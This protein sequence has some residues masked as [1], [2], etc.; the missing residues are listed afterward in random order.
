MQSSTLGSESDILGEIPPIK[1]LD[2]PNIGPVRYLKHKM[3]SLV[4]A[5]C[6]VMP[7]I[8]ESRKVLHTKSSKT[9]GRDKSAL[10]FAFCCHEGHKFRLLYCST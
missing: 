2:F 8:G 1:M 3:T 4:H 5:Y 10:L 6:K 9:H 7:L